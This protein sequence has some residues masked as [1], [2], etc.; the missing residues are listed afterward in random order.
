M[1]GSRSIFSLEQRTS[2]LLGFVPTPG[3]DESVEQRQAGRGICCIGLHSLVQACQFCVVHAFPFT[4][5]HVRSRRERS[6][7]DMQ[8]GTQRF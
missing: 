4:S 3:H 6:T 8:P 1:Y 5:S 2:H 7:L